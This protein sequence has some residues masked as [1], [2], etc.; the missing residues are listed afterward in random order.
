[1]HD[2]NRRHWD[3]AARAWQRL[4]ERDRLW[5]RCSREPALAFEGRALD[6]IRDAFPDLR[7]RR[8]CVIGSGDNYAA[9]ALA[10][11]G[12]EVTSTDISAAQLEVAAERAA[13]LGLELTFVRSDAAGLGPLASGTCDLVCSTNG[14]FVWIA[15]PA[16]VFAAVYR[17]LKPGGHYIFYDVHPFQRPWK[18]QV[19][20]LE[21]AKPY[22]ATGPFIESDPESNADAATYEFHWTMADLLNGL[23]DSGLG[24]RRIAESP[25]ATRFWQDAAY[26]P[27]TDDR[28]LDW[29]YNPRAGLPVWLTVDA[30]K[31]Q[32]G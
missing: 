32:G 4:R 20:P 17:V 3:A 27:G 1:M 14:L 13:Q 9:F 16:R 21:M 26:V 22:G 10:G 25:A 23:A 5:R 24:L 31:A 29:R 19:A 28:L 15:D 8:A 6:F 2:A 30:E 18:D 11:L 12:A 7:G